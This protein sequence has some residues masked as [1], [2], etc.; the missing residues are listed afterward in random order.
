[1]STPFFCIFLLKYS[2]PLADK[3]NKEVLMGN[4]MLFFFSAVSFVFTL[5]MMSK[6]AH[7]EKKQDLDD[8]LTD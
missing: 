4:I 5:K 7:L 6:L 1:M 8:S 2:F 3:G